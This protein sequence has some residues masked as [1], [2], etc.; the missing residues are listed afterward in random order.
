MLQPKKEDKLLRLLREKSGTYTIS[1][2][3]YISRDMN[4]PEVRKSFE[5][6]FEQFRQLGR[7]GG[8]ASK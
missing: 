1:K 2:D 4:H 5:R 7:N 6:Q 8:L 3:G